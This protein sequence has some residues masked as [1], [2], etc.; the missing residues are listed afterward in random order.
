MICGGIK[1]EDWQKIF[2][3][4]MTLPLPRTIRGKVEVRR[5]D[6]NDPQLCCEGLKVEINGTVSPAE[7]K[8]ETTV[9][10]FG[11]VDSSG[12]FVVS[13]PERYC[14]KE[15]VKII[16]SDPLSGRKQQFVKTASEII[17]SA[18]ELELV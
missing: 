15:S 18:D 17:E 14:F 4:D 10:P 5:R 13:M 11:I 6:D 2:E 3:R 7:D 1:D 16:I 8:A 9:C 12:N